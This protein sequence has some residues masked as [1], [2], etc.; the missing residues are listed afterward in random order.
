M[1]ATRTLIKR[2]SKKDRVAWLTLNRPEKKNALSIEL[3]KSLIR[4]LNEISEDRDINVIVLQAAGDSFCSGLDLYDHRKSHAAERLWGRGSNSQEIV[5]LLRMAPQITIAAVQGY[6]L[7]G[8][9]VLANACDLAVAAT[10]AK[11]GMPEILRG[12]YGAVAT[13]TL[14]HAGI[15]NKIAFHM[16]LTGRNMDGNEAARWGLVS[17]VVLEK[18]LTNAVRQLAIEIAQRHRVALAHAK[19]AAYA[20]MDLPMFQ[21]LQADEAISHRMRYYMNPLDDVEKYLKSQKG[22]GSLAYRKPDA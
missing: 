2:V 19:I 13:P 18:D 4:A 7:G 21:A 1:A 20:E 15:P 9:L 10:T 14:F 6:C 22:G 17:Q 3:M 8:G 12:S 5:R 11:L 16:Q